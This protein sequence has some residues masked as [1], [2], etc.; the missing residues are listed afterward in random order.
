MF[1]RLPRESEFLSWSYVVVWSLIIYV[2][3]PFVRIGVRYVRG[4]WGRESFTYFVAA[5]VILATAAAV[6]LLLKSKRKP[7]ASY[8]WLLGVGGVIVYLTFDLKAGS[9]EEAI[10]Y[11]QYGLLSL[12]LFS[13]FV[14]RIRDVSIYAVVTITGTI[15]GMV[16]ET[17]QWIAPDR[18]FGFRDFWLNFTAVAL[19]QVAV[20]LGIR[21]RLISGWP[22]GA[23]WRRLCRLAA[24]AVAYLGLC[25]LNT[26]E[27][28]AWYTAQVPLLGF[29]DQKRDLMVEYGQWLGDPATGLFRSRLTAEELR[30]SDRDRAE[31]GARI[32]DRYRDREQYFEFLEIYTPVADPFLHE[33]RVRLFRRDTYLERA[34]L[35]EQEDLRRRQFNVAYWENRILEA[36]FSELLRASDYGWPAELAAE[37]RKHARTD[38][39]HISGVSRSLITAVDERQVFWLTLV[40]V[41]GLLLLGSTLGRRMPNRGEG[42]GRESHR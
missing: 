7:V 11:L 33:A 10:H 6:I 21:P 42:A 4:E 1:E 14:H 20:A 15:V 28:V 41:V 38:E 39:V 26:P 32:I 12:L 22:D 17:I 19:V 16:D 25:H 40:S 37:V 34:R 30:R 5:A 8:A 35:A 3:I 2:T 24:L 23:S 29:F 27:R 36:N 31:E 9:P 18:F 13:A